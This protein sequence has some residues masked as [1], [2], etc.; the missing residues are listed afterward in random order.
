[1]ARIAPQKFTL[2]SF[3]T[4]ASWI[5]NLLSPLNTFL[6]DLVIQF[7]NNLSIADNLFQEIKEIR[8]KNETNEF[9]LRFRTKFNVNPK[10]LLLIFIYDNTTSSPAALNPAIGW[11]F[12]N[13]EIQISSISGL[14]ASKT[15]TIRLLVIYG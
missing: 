5:G 4:Q 14:T 9:P 11:E 2:E 12:I 1:M 15:Y 7:S 3:P 8:F 6:N 10:G 13:G